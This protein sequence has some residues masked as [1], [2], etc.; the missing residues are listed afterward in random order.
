M[1]A[2]EGVWA[3]TAKTR[4]P[5]TDRPTDTHYRGWKGADGTRDRDGKERERGPTPCIT[6]TALQSLLCLSPTL[7]LAESPFSSRLPTSSLFLPTF[8]I[9]LPSSAFFFH[10]NNAS[11]RCIY[12][13]CLSSLFRYFESAISAQQ[14]FERI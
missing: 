6:Y 2:K 11:L 5:D 1:I 14:S 8:P 3:R 10:F 7:S 12:H 4:D 13:S 9:S